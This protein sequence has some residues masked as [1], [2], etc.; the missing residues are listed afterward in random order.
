MSILHIS[1]GVKERHMD[2]LEGAVAVSVV[3]TSVLFD[4]ERLAQGSVNLVGPYHTDH[5]QLVSASCDDDGAYLAVPCDRPVSSTGVETAVMV[6]VSPSAA[7]GAAVVCVHTVDVADHPA[8]RF[9][10]YAC[11]E[12]AVVGV[13][14]AVA[15]GGPDVAWRA[16]HVALGAVG[17]WEI[18]G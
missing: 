11:T 18:G 10:N 3:N 4:I 17:T 13:A 2:T 7:S 5:R 1:A 16:K 6:E 8:D 15:G 9:H 12:L 14:A